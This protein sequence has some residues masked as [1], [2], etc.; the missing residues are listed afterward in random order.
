MNL[1]NTYSFY[2]FTTIGWW[3][4]YVCN[5][6]MISWRRLILV[7]KLLIAYVLALVSGKRVVIFAGPHKSASS[8]IQEFLVQYCTGRPK[9]RKHKA[10]RQWRWPKVNYTNS[11]IPAR[12]LLS[13]LVYNKTE[14]KPL[15]EAIENSLKADFDKYPNLVLGTEE[16]DRFGWSSALVW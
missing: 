1:I 4:Y 8:T 5:S 2:L 15:I 13:R 12:K 16:L 11:K 3:P 14:D 7:L 10:F 9:F 6:I